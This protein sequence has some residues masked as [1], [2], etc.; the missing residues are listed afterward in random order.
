LKKFSGTLNL[1]NGVASTD[2]LTGVLNAGTISAN[3]TVSLVSQEINMHMSAV[4]GSATSQSVG[5]SGIGG[6]M[7]TALANSKGELVVPVMVTGNMAH[8]I[9]TPDTAA[10]AKMKLG[11]LLP[12]TAGILGRGS[13]GLGGA[14]NGILGGQQNSGDAK[15]KQQQQ[16]NP[17]GSILDQFKKKKPQ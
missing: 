16:A 10:I 8:P 4:L 5:G 2:N 3:G 15:A 7:S 6:F 14:L 17:L 12:S 9:V 1:V 11:N 13:K